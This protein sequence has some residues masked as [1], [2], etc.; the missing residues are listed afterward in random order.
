MLGFSAVIFVFAG[1]LWL[2]LFAE[3]ICR[4]YYNE[5]LK[6]LLYMLYHVLYILHMK[7]LVKLDFAFNLNM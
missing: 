3:L 6:Y 4:C 5:Y 7:F 1:L 2:F